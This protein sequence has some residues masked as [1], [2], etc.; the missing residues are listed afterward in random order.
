MLHRTHRHHEPR[1][2][3]A[4]LAAAALASCSLLAVPAAS[5]PTPA[6]A[7]GDTE[8]MKAARRELF[9]EA[10]RDMAAKQ[11]EACRVKT[12]GAWAARKHPQVASLLGICEVELGL[13]RDAAEHL[14]YALENGEGEEPIRGPQVKEA[15]AKAQA[16][17]G[18]V[19]ATAAQPGVELRV[20]ETVIGPAPA[21][22][23]FEP[24]EHALEARLEGHA[25]GREALTLA[26][27]DRKELRFDL[28]PLAA[29]TGGGGSGAELPRPDDEPRAPKPL[30]PAIVLGG[31]GAVGVGLGITGFVLAGSARSEADDI[32][33]AAAAGAGCGPD[34][35]RCPDGVDALGRVDTMRGLGIAGVAVGGA[36][37][38]GLVIYL[39]LPRGSAEETSMWFAPT[40]GESTGLSLG[41]R[42]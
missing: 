9:A 16:K 4:L 24:G 13:F 31:V 38:T 32:A 42:F 5:Q 30:W 8:A 20:G 34:G 15:F 11:W 22:I 39:V 7:S 26:A 23:F 3:R 33:A 6:A 25:P 21:T 27:G 35:S 2:P 19:V 28:A 14:H 12:L 37:L 29:G 10:L 36:A 1:A 40:V 18:T 41:G 17:V